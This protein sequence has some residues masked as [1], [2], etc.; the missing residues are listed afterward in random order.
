MAAEIERLC[1]KIS[2]MGG[3]GGGTKGDRSYR[4]RDCWWTGSGY[5]LFGRETLGRKT[6][7]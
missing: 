3:G 7:K 5:T 4:R 2:V 1:S 6:S